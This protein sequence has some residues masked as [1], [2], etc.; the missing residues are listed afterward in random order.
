V[1]TL[2]DDPDRRV[3]RA[4]TLAGER[5]FAAFLASPPAAGL[6]S[7][8]RIVSSTSVTGAR[9]EHLL[10]GRSDAALLLEHER[11]PFPSYPAEWPPEM[12]HA[13]ASLTLDLAR[14][15]LPHHIGLKDATP[16][17][18]LFRGPAPIFIDVLSFERREPGDSTWAPYGQ[19]LRT[20]LLPLLANRRLHMPLDQVFATRRDGLEPEDVLRWTPPLQ[21]L[22]P[23][24]LSLV[25]LPSWLGAHHDQDDAAMYRKRVLPD[26]DKAQ[27]ILDALF[28]R[29]ERLL[30]SVAPAANRK[31]TWSD[32]LVSNN[33]YSAGHFAGKEEFVRDALTEFAPR[34]VLDA[35]CNT[36]HFSVLAASSGA[37]V[38]AIDYDP[39]VVGALWRHARTEK[40]PILPLVV[41]LSRPTPASGWNNSETPS[42]LDRARGHFDAVLMLALIHHL[43]VTERIPL[44]SV[45]DLA[46]DLVSRSDGGIALIEFIAP[47]DSM[48]RRLVRGREELYRHLTREH[49]E[50]TARRR[51]DIVRFH[52]CEGTHRW[53][54]LLRRRA[55]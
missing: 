24:C 32:Y 5:D 9:R 35:G 22:L 2:H 26:S 27:Y 10:A 30:A 4:V 14:T 43:L 23:P 53:L 46:A 47:E 1:F 18:V 42:F 44:E 45:L 20:F 29:L 13:A 31:S 48:F 55:R 16:Y 12:L 51:F 7:S 49:F 28:R 41:N 40:L 3:Y 8:G 37:D 25:T 6:L 17:N 36:G 15:L 34:R 19:F 11:I 21:R 54:Y 50:S 38:T 52:H 39:V 33:N